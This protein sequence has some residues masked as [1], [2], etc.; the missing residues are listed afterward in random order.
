[1]FPY[2]LFFLSGFFFNSV[3]AKERVLVSAS[4]V[5][6]PHRQWLKRW[7]EKG[8]KIKQ[9]SENQKLP[10][11]GRQPTEVYVQESATQDSQSLDVGLKELTK[12]NKQNTEEYLYPYF[13]SPHEGILLMSR[14]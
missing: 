1:M 4:K 2:V 10:N 9:V 5:G 7:I 8:P 11:Q 6:S 12:W 3:R 13:C 14:Y